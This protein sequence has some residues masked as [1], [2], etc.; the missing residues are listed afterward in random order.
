MAGDTAMNSAAKMDATLPRPSP[1]GSNSNT[2]SVPKKT[3]TTRRM[4]S[5]NPA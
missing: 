3:G 1:I 2:S 4:N 5:L